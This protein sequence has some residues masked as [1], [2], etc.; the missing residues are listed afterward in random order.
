MRLLPLKSNQNVL[1]GAKVK[2]DRFLRSA[3]LCALWT[4]LLA[5]AVRVGSSRDDDFGGLISPCSQCVHV[6]VVT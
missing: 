4:L 3:V 6:C 5:V 1:I 2:G